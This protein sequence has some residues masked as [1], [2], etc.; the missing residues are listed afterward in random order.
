LNI[1]FELRRISVDFHGH[2]FDPRFCA[3]FSP[4]SA[5]LLVTPQALSLV[6]SRWRSTS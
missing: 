5:C 2:V 6:V 1:E 4:T 3:Q